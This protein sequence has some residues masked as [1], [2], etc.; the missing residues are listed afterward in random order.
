MNE[1]TITSTDIPKDTYL[2]MCKF[3]S[4]TSHPRILDKMK[5]EKDGKEHE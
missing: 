3:F 1:K 5:N 2:E 4:R